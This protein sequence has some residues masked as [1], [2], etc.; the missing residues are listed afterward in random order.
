MTGW[1]K[2]GVAVGVLLG[3]TVVGDRVT[4][5]VAER[6]LASEVQ[7]TEQLIVEPSVDIHGFPFLTQALGGRYDQIDL[8]ARGLQREGLTV[9]R[10][11]ATLRGVD[12]GFIDAMS[13][14]VGAVP[15]DEVNA[16][17]YVTFRE[18]ERRIGNRGLRLSAA[19][20]RSVRVRGTVA[21]KPVSVLSGVSVSG[22]EVRIRAQR[23]ESGGLALAAVGTQFDVTL[24][25]PALPF[26]LRLTG[27]A[28]VDDAV[29]VA[30][31]GRDVILR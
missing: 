28:V 15:V 22:R 6:A 20:D 4:V 5:G 26:K 14:D 12:I 21:G 2:T 7:Q 13:G 19:G 24:T 30:A 3:A 9:A 23:V 10:F 27:A 31:A 8:R 18:I 16:T 1:G 25:M 17:A 29:A 11:E